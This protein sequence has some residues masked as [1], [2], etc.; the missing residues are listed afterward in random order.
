ML[1]VMGSLFS[2][3]P[4]NAN[5]DTN[6]TDNMNPQSNLDDNWKSDLTENELNTWERIMNHDE[7]KFQNINER[8]RE[9]SEVYLAGRSIRGNSNE[10]LIFG[11]DSENNEEN[12]MD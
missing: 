5:N 8:N 6:V 2:S 7:I 1:P 11:A 4:T 12:G 9:L 10:F 3:N